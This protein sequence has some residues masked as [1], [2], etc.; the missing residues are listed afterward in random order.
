MVSS[1]W[2]I[3]RISQILP[4]DTEALQQILDYASSLPKLVAAEHLKGILGDSPQALEFISSFN[5]QREV[6]DDI[7]VE[8][9]PPSSDL[10]ARKPR[11][12]KAPLN[13]LPPP[14]VPEDHG[15]T[16]GAYKKKKGDD[17]FSGARRPHKEPPSANKFDL[18]EKPSAYQLTTA[19]PPPLASGPLISDLPNVRSSRVTPVASKTKINVSGGPSMHG[20]STTLQDLVRIC[21]PCIRPR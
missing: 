13:K 3:S 17:Y 16:S 11:K 15:N 12:K 6:P 21:P 5:S 4:L 7:Q 2:A 8:P 14:R 9:A 19:K 1:T 10:P 20:A 18:S